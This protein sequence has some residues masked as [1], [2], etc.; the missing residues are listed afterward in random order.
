MYMTLTKLVY[1]L[2]IQYS[3]AKIGTIIVPTWWGWKDVNAQYCAWYHS[4][5]S[6]CWCDSLM[7]LLLLRHRSRKFRTGVHVAFLQLLG[8]TEAILEWLQNLRLSHD[9]HCLPCSLENLTNV[10]IWND[11]PKFDSRSGS[12]VWRKSV[13]GNTWALSTDNSYLSKPA[14]LNWL[15]L[16]QMLPPWNCLHWSL[17]INQKIFTEHPKW[18][19]P[20]GMERN[21]K[22]V[23]CSPSHPN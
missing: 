14:N 8:Y 1:P 15:C 5:I 21:G 10:D 18:A 23:P 7:F 6:C 13:I 2:Y 11:F 19:N 4:N 20:W 22:P 16:F 9:A 3:P 12:E 17:A